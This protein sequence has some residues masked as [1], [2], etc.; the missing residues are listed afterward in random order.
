MHLLTRTL[1]V[2]VCVHSQALSAADIFRH[3]APPP[4]WQGLRAPTPRTPRPAVRLTSARIPTP[5]AGEPPAL[6][7]RQ[8]SLG[9]GTG[10]GP[11]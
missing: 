1:H 3:T 10:P 2:Q 7:I 6:L 9:P 8:A 4:L 5:R 11:L